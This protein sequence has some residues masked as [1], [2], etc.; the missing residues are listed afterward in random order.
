LHDPDHQ[1]FVDFEWRI[2]ERSND[3]VH[4]RG[5]VFVGRLNRAPRAAMRVL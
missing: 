5:K 4:G 3:D 1:P 2:A